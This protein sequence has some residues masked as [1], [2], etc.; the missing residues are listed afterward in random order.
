MARLI[1]RTNNAYTNVSNKV[2]RDA[3]LSWKARGIFIY[4]W[5]QSDNWNFY[6]SE[7]ERH[8]VDGRESLQNGLKELENAG[9]LVRSVKFDEIKKIKGMEWILSD[10]PSNG[11]PVQGKTRH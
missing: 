2:V 7:I 11:K 3:S 9:Y 10:F 4:L 5:S 1:K 8:S 6:V